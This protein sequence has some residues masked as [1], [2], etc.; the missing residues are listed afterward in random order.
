MLIIFACVTPQTSEQ[1][2]DKIL[3]QSNH[4]CN[5]FTVDKPSQLIPCYLIIAIVV[6]S[7]VCVASTFKFTKTISS[8]LSF[9]TLLIDFTWQTDQ[10]QLHFDLSALF[11]RL[12]WDAMLPSTGQ[13]L[14]QLVHWRSQTVKPFFRRLICIVSCSR[15]HWIYWTCISKHHCIMILLDLS[16]W[17]WWFSCLIILG[18]NVIIWSP[19]CTCKVWHVNYTRAHAA[20]QRTSKHLV[21]HI[22]H[23]SFSH[24]RQMLVCL[25]STDTYTSHCIIYLL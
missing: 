25:Y 24:M 6:F 2:F 16:V 17:L 23:F 22:F 19:W 15:E 9:V 1:L 4:K 13:L 10:S 3:W 8:F 5:H 18:E 11:T 14:F 12:H 20:L 21:S 7:N